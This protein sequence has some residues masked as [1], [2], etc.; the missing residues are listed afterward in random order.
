MSEQKGFISPNY[1]QTPNDFFDFIKVMEM[2]ELKCLLAIIRATFGWHREEAMLSL[3]VLEK[4]TGLSRQ[5]VIDGMTRL[6]DR[7]LIWKKYDE[8]TKTAIY[9]VNV[10]DYPPP[11]GEEV[12]NSVDYP[13]PEV[14]NS[15]DSG[16]VHSIDTNKESINKENNIKE[17]INDPDFSV[18]LHRLWYGIKLQLMMQIRNNV[19]APGIQSSEALE[20]DPANSAIKVYFPADSIDYVNNCLSGTINKILISL[21]D[22]KYD[23]VIALPSERHGIN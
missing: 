7:G 15:V 17:S 21:T 6:K 10:L 22:G 23:H 8:A 5:G 12:V 9:G 20:Y 4:M 13:S 11:V 1:T 18:N 16:V 19:H 14:V 2:S 3:S